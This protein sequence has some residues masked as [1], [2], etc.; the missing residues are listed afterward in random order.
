LSLSLVS[1]ILQ[2]T[3]ISRCALATPGAYHGPPK[4]DDYPRGGGG[5]GYRPC[6]YTFLTLYCTSRD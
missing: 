4:R 3:N 6:E 5:G 1:I 2:E